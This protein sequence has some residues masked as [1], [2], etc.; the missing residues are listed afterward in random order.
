MK[1]INVSKTNYDFI[2][3]L[4]RKYSLKNNNEVISIMINALDKYTELYGEIEVD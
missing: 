4:R 2:V 3:N 1:H